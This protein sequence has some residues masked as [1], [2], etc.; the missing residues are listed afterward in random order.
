[1]MRPD[2]FDHARAKCTQSH[3]EKEGVEGFD[4]KERT[5]AIEQ[6]AA[7]LRCEYFWALPYLQPA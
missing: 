4:E 6:C 1:M 3:P 7:Q 2:L 5:L